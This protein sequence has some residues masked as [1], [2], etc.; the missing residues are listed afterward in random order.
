MVLGAALTCFPDSAQPAGCKI[1]LMPFCIS[2]S[3]YG[4]CNWGRLQVWHLK[5]AQPNL[6]FLQMAGLENSFT[7]LFLERVRW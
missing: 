2:Q 7:E 4:E 1:G 5:S 6:S 3:L